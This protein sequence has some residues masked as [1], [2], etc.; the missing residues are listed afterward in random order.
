MD[1]SENQLRDFLTERG[2]NPEV[3]L[4]VIRERISR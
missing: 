2:H 4:T 1:Y 3:P